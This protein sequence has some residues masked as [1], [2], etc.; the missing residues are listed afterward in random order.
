MRTLVPETPRRAGRTLPGR[1]G[2]LERR[3]GDCRHLRP[4]EAKAGRAVELRAQGSGRIHGDHDLVGHARESP[5]DRESLVEGVAAVRVPHRKRPLVIR[6]CNPRCT[7]G[8][9]F[10]RTACAPAEACRDDPQ[11][12][13]G[14]R[15]DL[16]GAGRPHVERKGA[17][18]M[19]RGAGRLGR[20]AE[21][22]A[23][24][25]RGRVRS[26]ERKP[27]ANAAASASCPRPLQRRG[28]ALRASMGTAPPTSAYVVP[29]KP[30]SV[31]PTAS[32]CSRPARQF[33]RGR[34]R[35]RSENRAW[36]EMRSL[37]GG[38]PPCQAATWETTS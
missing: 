26:K 11:R 31:F 13:R 3:V 19:D 4:F 1:V 35:C 23:R 25:G 29:T 12:I 24:R 37:L 33:P 15:G 21:R 36:P 17:R 32:R 34:P 6:R 10:E 27:T 30:S 38:G 28:Q 16:E 22:G 20:G 7:L 8:G 2:Y 9:A 18:S 14:P 5:G